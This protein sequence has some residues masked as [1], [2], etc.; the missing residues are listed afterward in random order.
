MTDSDAFK[1]AGGYA[2]H[3]LF[4]YLVDAS[5]CVLSDKDMSIIADGYGTAVSEAGE[6]MILQALLQSMGEGFSRILFEGVINRMP[7]RN[8][9]DFV[10]KL[11]RIIGDTESVHDAQRLEKIRKI[12]DRLIDSDKARRMS[13]M[14]QKRDIDSRVREIREFA[15]FQNNLNNVLSKGEMNL[16]SRQMLQSLIGM[17][18]RL[19]S[20]NKVQ[21][22]EQ[23]TDRLGDA[24]IDGEPDIRAEVS[25]ILFLI[26]EKLISGKMPDLMRRN[27]HKLA[28]WIK[29]ENQVT[30]EYENISVQLQYLCQT[31]IRNYRFAD[32]THILKVFHDIYVGNIQKDE[33]FQTLAGDV[34]RGVGTTS[35]LAPL[36]GEFSTNEKNKRRTAS[37]CLSYL[38][39]S[40]AKTL[41]ETLKNSP[42]R[43]ERARILKVLSNIG[44]P[45]IPALLTELNGAETWYYI[46]NLI[47]LIGRSG[48]ESRLDNLRPFLTY[49]DI[50]VQ[51]EA[52]NS[53]F[54][55]GGNL[56]GETL[57][58]TLLTADDRLKIRIVEMLGDLRYTD[59]VPYLLQLLE[60][61]TTL[62]V[63][64]G[65]E[66]AEKMINALGA[67]GSQEAVSM[68]ETISSEKIIASKKAN[69]K[70]VAAASDAL[71]VIKDRS[72]ALDKT[73]TLR[74][75]RSADGQVEFEK[76]DE[77][78]N[79]PRNRDYM[80]TWSELYKTLTPNETDALYHSLVQA[81]FH[82]EQVLFRQGEPNSR[83][84]FID[85]GEVVLAYDQGQLIGPFGEDQ[86]DNDEDE[87]VWIK[88]L[89]SGNVAG[90]ESFFSNS[91]STVSLR[92][93][94]EVD[95]RFLENDILEEWKHEFPQLESKLLAFCEK[96]EKVDDILKQFGMERRFDN[97]VEISGP[98]SVQ[99]L[100]NARRPEKRSYT[101]KFFDLSIGGACF[102][103]RLPEKKSIHHL[104]GRKLRI[105]CNIQNDGHNEDVEQNGTIV[106][107]RFL[108][109]S[110]E[111]RIHM[112]F[113]RVIIHITDVLAT[114]SPI[115]SELPAKEEVSRNDFLKTKIPFS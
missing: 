29:I 13:V 95:V 65:D 55:V 61:E 14:A 19:I 20:E 74:V 82:E 64:D 68:L 46:R 85:D 75:K 106:G 97:R 4:D 22:A 105:K 89:K 84:F 91:I 66:L 34:L 24:L 17:I 54:N 103:V 98:M 36:L 69:K 112:K 26:G 72:S 102:D 77:K 35:V 79:A 58:A 63:E 12:R 33:S 76:K 107:I 109:A 99:F 62:T 16:E 37:E 115:R 40:S 38:G 27:S 21:A 44:S 5:D 31:L 104:L 42:D 92:A 94:T 18:D 30:P 78:K 88:T 73:V 90:G 25:Q 8:F 43:N 59:A 15:Q 80:N 70:L 113:D 45:S 81:E 87:E 6:E 23:I 51:R 3:K 1:V 93:I 96:F 57:L 11:D 39:E 49:P 60:T 2:V 9:D 32:C 53:I 71:E 101:G 48:D 111:Y 56:R 114:D 108:N 110:K 100:D 52:L 41:L 50:R 7:D 83:L 28:E 47:L 10:S 86:S 67:I